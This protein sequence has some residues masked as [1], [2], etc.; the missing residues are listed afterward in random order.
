M[1]ANKII[2]TDESQVD[3]IEGAR[4]ARLALRSV[5]LNVEKTHK[6]LK[7]DSLKK[8]Q[9]LDL[10]KRTLTGYIE[11]IEEHLQNQ[12]DFVKIK[13]QER[14]AKLLR[15]R[16]ELL[17]PFRFEGDGLG[18]IPFSEMDDRAFETFLIGV[19]SAHE[20][21]EQ[22]KAES[23]RIKIEN[24]RLAKEEL[25]RIHLENERLRK[26]AD[27]RE[28]VLKQE[29]KKAEL[30]RREQEEKLRI[31]RE[32]RER[33]EREIKIREELEEQERKSQL[34]A[35]RKLKRAPDKQKLLNFA[36]RIENIEPVTGLRDD[37]AIKIYNG[38]IELLAK[39]VK[40][41][42]DKSETI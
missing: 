31:E 23:E 41:L 6:L 20:I 32:E 10:I 13:E 24:E 35:E 8:G 29:R 34:S 12:E 26:E 25:Q 42:K 21:R 4:T 16:L 7:E 22:E 39:V 14:K 19:K 15:E 33:V 28:A 30:E 18:S 38:A 17:S 2:V 11:P 1:E 37:D 40:Y 27:K 36:A 5:R 9:L 3:L